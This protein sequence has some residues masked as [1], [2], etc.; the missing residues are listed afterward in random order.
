MKPLK[1]SEVLREAWHLI[2]QPGKWTQYTRARDLNGKSVEP[3]SHAA[4]CF[5]SIGAV[6]HVGVKAQQRD[7]R[8]ARLALGRAG[9]YSVARSN[10]NVRSVTELAPMWEQA[11]ILAEHDES[12]NLQQSYCSPA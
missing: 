7:A 4:V 1:P 5:C 2:Q 9:R 6:E 3:T 10:D 8:R 12:R 11:I